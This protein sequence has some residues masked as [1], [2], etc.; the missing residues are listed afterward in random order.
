MQNGFAVFARIPNVTQETSQFLPTVRGLNGNGVATGGGGAVSGASP[1]MSSYVDGVA[2]TYGAAP[3]GQGSFWDMAQVEVYRGAQSTLFG[4]NASA[5]VLVQTT[6]SPVFTDGYAAQIGL[7]NQRTTYNT[8]LMLNKALGDRLALRFTSELADGKSAID[9]SPVA[10]TGLNADDREALGR[11]QYGRLRLKALY[12]PVDQLSVKL[13]VEQ[14]Q[15]KNPYPPDLAAI[16][17]RR[18]AR[19]DGYGYFDSKNRIV[20]LTTT[21]EISPDWTFD[22]VLSK[23]KAK[24]NFG[25]PPAGQPDPA[26]FLDFTF[27]SD[28]TAIEP[29]LVYKAAQGR[30]SAV[31]GLYAKRR[32][33]DD[34]GAPGSSFVLTANDR[35]RSHSVYLDATLQ[36]SPAWDLLAA[37]RY[38]NDRQ[39]R[40]FSA[41]DGALAFDFVARNR[42]FLPKLGAS[43]HLSPDASVSAVAYKGYNASGGGVSFVSFT[44]YQ[45]K[46]ETSDTVEL[47]TRSQWL[48]GQLTVNANLFYTRLKD[49]QASGIGPGGPDDSIFLNIAKAASKG[50]EIDLA[51]QP[52]QQTRWHAGI[53]WLHTRIVNFGSAENTLINGNQLPLAPRLSANLGGTFAASRSLTFG[54]DLAYSGKRFSDLEN[55]ADGRVASATVMN[56]HVQYR[57]GK[58]KLT[59]FVNNLFDRLVQ[60]SRSPGGAGFSA[61]A[62][63][64]DP[65]TL[66]VNLQRDF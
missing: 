19:P 13:M 61:F 29:K 14:E 9:Y 23:Q 11:V 24:T 65:R 26:E 52:S 57:F 5:G 45:F 42:V 6:N 39:Q 3:D 37:A 53:G 54:A 4:Q 58:F 18:E 8:A 7:R 49:T 40:R 32:D 2:R 33:R 31:A 34:V 17:D 59:G 1:R 22:T 38:Q 47:V 15:R 10:G 63:I 46:K 35:A 16:S 66:G 36:L 62:Y 44:P 55:L 27:M 64:N 48:Q 43:F 12:L 21:Y 60:R 41:F 28:E 30:T 51:Y 20:S 56:A 25:P 50:L